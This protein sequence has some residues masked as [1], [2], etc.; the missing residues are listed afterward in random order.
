VTAR[1]LIIGHRGASA[2]APEN[3]RAAF[4]LALSEGADGIEFDVRLSQDNKPVVIHDASLKRTSTNRAFVSAM[5][6]QDLATI[7]VGSWF[8]SKFLKHAR[9]DY[10]KEK[11]PSLEDVF[12]LFSKSEGVLYLEMKFE[13][14]GSDILARQCVDLIREYAFTD[15]VV[16][17]CF[18]LASIAEVKRLDGGIRT[19]ALFEPSIKQPQSI[20]KRLRMVEQAEDCGAD[21][22]ALHHRL[23]TPRVVERAAELKMECVVWTV[24]D[25]RWVS[26]AERLGLKALITNNPGPMVK[27]RATG[28]DV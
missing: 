5:S 22:I 26:K 20:L 19:A 2:L 17:E 8:N 12:K 6:S 25:P 15:R 1:P 7:D 9:P 16:V 10:Q 13:K 24:D 21:E 4:S 11:L 28:T 23:V 3:T 27:A 14:T 18:H